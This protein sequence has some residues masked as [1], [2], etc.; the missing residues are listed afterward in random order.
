M[1]DSLS[2]LHKVP[3]GERR[4]AGKPTYLIRKRVQTLSSNLDTRA[5]TFTNSYKM[6]PNSS[7]PASRLLVALGIQSRHG[8]VSRTMPSFLSGRWVEATHP[9]LDV[10]LVGEARLWPAAGASVRHPHL[11]TTLLLPSP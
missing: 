9:L 8:I 2:S 1:S 10:L 5:E 11:G 6:S 7:L 3:I 4:D